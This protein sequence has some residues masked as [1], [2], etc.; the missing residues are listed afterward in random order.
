MQNIYKL[1]HT[2]IVFKE[3]N[4]RIHVEYLQNTFRNIRKMTTRESICSKRMNKMNHIA[5]IAL[6]KSDESLLRRI[7]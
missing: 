6:G 2:H 4:L 1:G 5:R 7:R 3:Q